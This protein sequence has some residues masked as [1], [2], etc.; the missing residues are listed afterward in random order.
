MSNLKRS[1]FWVAF[2]L[3]IIFFLGQLDRVDRP[4]INLASYFYVLVFIVVPCMVLIPPFYRAP[5]FISMVFWASIYFALSRFL[6]RSLSAPDSFETIFIEIVLLELGVW[7][8]YQLAVDLAHSESLVDTMAQSAFPNQAIEIESATTSI[9]HEVTRSRRYHRPLSLL[10]FHVVSEDKDLYREL[11]RTFQRDLLNRFSSAR[12]GQL[13]GEQIRQTDILLRDRV[14]SFVI[15]CPE[16]DKENVKL[17]GERISSRLKDGTGLQITWGS[18]S[19]PDEALT[20]DDML[21]RARERMT[22]TS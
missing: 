9:R 11:F 22:S 17:L 15:L 3:A 21:A 13:I 2:Y 14:G 19:F 1:F 10:I 6:D 7:L 5:Q 8:S 12:M 20:F 4:V 18:A 16:T